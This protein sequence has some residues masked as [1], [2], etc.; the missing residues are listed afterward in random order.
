[1][2]RINVAIAVAEEARDR[3]YEVA[4]VCRALGFAHTS[5]LSNI[6]I[7]IGSADVEDLPLLRAIPGVLAVEMERALE[8]AA[9]EG[10]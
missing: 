10:G 6:G 9:L 1:M 4:E 3:I 7:L 8:L 5:T 2:M